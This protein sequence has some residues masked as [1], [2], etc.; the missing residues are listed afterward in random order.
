MKKATSIIRKVVIAAIGVPVF[1][2][3]LILIPAPGPGI[4]VCFLGL[5]ILS[6]EFDWAKKHRD[7]A[8][9]HLDRAIKKS[10]E[11]QQKINKNSR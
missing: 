5:L 4:L 6:L 11:R 10:K 8:R 1:I 3:G 2:L 7:N 9:G